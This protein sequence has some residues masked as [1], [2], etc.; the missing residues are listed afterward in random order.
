MSQSPYEPA[1]GPVQTPDHRHGQPPPGHG[2]PGHGAP[3][4]D[5]PGYGTAGYAPAPQRTN[6]MAILGLVFAF[7]F[8]PLGLVFS[9]VGLS[10]TKKRGEGGRGLAIAGLILSILFLV[11]G[12]LLFFVFFAA[13]QEAAENAGPVETEISAPAAESPATEPADAQGVLAACQTIGPAMI[14]FESDMMTVTTPE[15]YALVITE[16]RATLE[17]AAAATTDPVFV[18]DVQ[19]LSDNLQLAADTVANGEDPTYLEAA[20]TEDGTRI[21]TDCADAGYTGP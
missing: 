7:V 5:P 3:G 6:V 11:L 21:D 14:E 12:I 9:A 1:P 20:L 19:L 18:Q 2:A 13:F 16:V 15:E 8:S 17:G 10:Q 4:Y